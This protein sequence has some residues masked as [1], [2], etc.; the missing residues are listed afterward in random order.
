MTADRATSNSGIAWPLA[1]ALTLLIWLL[2]RLTALS[3]QGPLTADADAYYTIVIARN[4]V[5][6]GLLSFDGQTLTNGFSPLWLTVLAAQRTLVGESLL[7][8]FAIEAAMLSASLF[9]LLRCLNVANRLFL[10]GFTAAFAWLAEGFGM[11]GL[12]ASLA[13][14]CVSLFVAALCW[15][16]ESLWGGLALAATA[17]LCLAARIETVLFLIPALVLAPTR[18]AN[19]VLGLGCFLAA[20]IAYGVIN[21]LHFGM[22]LPVTSEVHALGGVQLNRALFSQIALAWSLDGF[23]ARP[24]LLGLCLL[25][26]PALGFLAR[27]E[28]PAVALSAAA[29][30]GGWLVLLSLC[31]GSSWTVGPALGAVALWPLIALFWTLAPPL[32]DLLHR[33]HV[34]L[35]SPRLAQPAAAGLSGLMLASVLGQSALAASSGPPRPAVALPADPVR[36]LLALHGET[37]AG[38]P[39]AMGDGAGA[40]AAAY[41]HPV[42]ALKG[43]AGDGAYLANI[44]NSEDLTPLLCARGV[45]FAAA[46]LHSLDAYGRTRI[47]ALDPAQT[48]LAGAHFEVHRR[49][50]IARIPAADGRQLHVWR[51]GA[52]WRNGYAAQTETRRDL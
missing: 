25:M 43:V 33:L 49:D 35:G 21:L 23:S 48:S 37:L 44:I 7:I 5:E 17:I 38:G 12:D 1:C 24:I 13:A 41:G 4:W 40:L 27:P 22:V 9:I 42:I 39:I 50:E 30:V 2:A 8:T 52:C 32:S 18:L 3:L 14:F 34:R 46:Y 29:G 10:V 11:T 6:Q 45:K 47:G 31:F 28:T 51:L 19:R 20:M 16:T 15:R 36:T 26:A